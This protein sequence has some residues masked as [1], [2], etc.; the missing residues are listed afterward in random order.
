MLQK[1]GQEGKEGDYRLVIRKQGIP[2]VSDIILNLFFTEINYW[3]IPKLSTKKCAA[4]C[5]F[6]SRGKA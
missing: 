5:I 4:C 3:A 6:F 1:Q 2:L